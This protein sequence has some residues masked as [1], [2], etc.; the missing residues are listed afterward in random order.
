MIRLPN[1]VALILLQQAWR[2]RLHL[3]RFDDIE[4]EDGT[5]KQERHCQDYHGY[6]DSDFAPHPDHTDS[7]A[8]YYRRLGVESYRQP[9]P[10]TRHKVIVSGFGRV[11]PMSRS[12]AKDRKILRLLSDGIPIRRV[13]SQL[14]VGQGRVYRLLAKIHD[15]IRR[16]T[17]YGKATS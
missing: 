12:R 7:R 8:E 10:R 17:N 1:P 16:E 9:P 6:V 4:N 3:S 15:R 13:M 14:H 5:L 11:T 2:L